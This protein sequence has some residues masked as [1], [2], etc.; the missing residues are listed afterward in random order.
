MQISVASIIKTVHFDIAIYAQ[1]QLSQN[2]KPGIDFISLLIL[3]IL[4]LGR[5]LFN[6][7]AKA[8]GSVVSNRIGVKFVRNFLQADTHGL[9]EL[10]FRFDVTLLRWRPWSHFTQKSAAFWWVLSAH[11]APVGRI[12]I[13]VRQSEICS[14]F[15]LVIRLCGRIYCLVT[16]W[17]SSAL[18]WWGSGATLSSIGIR[19]T[20]LL[21]SS[22][23]SAWRI[24]VTSSCL[25][26]AA[27][28]ADN[29]LSSNRRSFICTRYFA[30]WALR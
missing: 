14:A 25:T 18:D 4:L 8:K 28:T 11:E 9:A 27:A 2:L 6:L 1:A 23:I 16:V 20:M 30:S 17:R 22:S 12:H 3:F 10:A 21:T 26:L 7:I 15:V 5:A 24:D 13:N 19:F 29:A